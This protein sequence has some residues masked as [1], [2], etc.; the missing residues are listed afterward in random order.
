MFLNNNNYTTTTTTVILV[1]RGGGM[2]VE[3]ERLQQSA[4]THS[5][6]EEKETLNI[7]VAGMNLANNMIK[8]SIPMK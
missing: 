2:G 3:K 7:N 6:A 8:I 5:G 4:S 1:P